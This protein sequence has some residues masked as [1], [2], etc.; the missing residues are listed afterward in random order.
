M[1]VRI[2]D[3]AKPYPSEERRQLPC[4]QLPVHVN[5]TVNR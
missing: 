4:T 3:G 1:S 5:V 2:Q